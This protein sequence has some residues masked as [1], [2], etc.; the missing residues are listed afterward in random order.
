MDFN[1]C[2]LKI[3]GD[4]RTYTDDELKSDNFLNK[5][6]EFFFILNC[7]WTLF[8]LMFQSRPP[9]F[10]YF[11]SSPFNFGHPFFGCLFFLVRNE[12]DTSHIVHANTV[13][14]WSNSKKKKSVKRLRKTVFNNNNLRK[15]GRVRALVSLELWGQ[16]H[17]R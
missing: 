17:L 1:D 2:R 6:N 12:M 15:S 4:V 5:R 11:F 14:K 16:R 10:V 8:A 3:G 9:A 13:K 7:L